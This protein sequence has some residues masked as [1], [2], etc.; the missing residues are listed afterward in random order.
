M[1]QLLNINQFGL[2]PVLGQV[3]WTIARRGTLTVMVSSNET[4]T[5]KASTPVILDPAAVGPMPQVILAGDADPKAFYPVLNS[6]NASYV[7]GE[8]LEVTGNFG[9]IMWCK[10]AATIA[11]GATVEN[12]VSTGT[13]QTNSA[14][15]AMGIAL[16]NGV[17]GN[18]VP[19]MLLTPCG[20]AS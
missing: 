17:L 6:K 3:D 5:V 11:M 12:V 16:L 18:L 14:S 13:V 8:V 2:S 7:A 10:A 1:S 9:P 4:G 15:K 20:V 19:I